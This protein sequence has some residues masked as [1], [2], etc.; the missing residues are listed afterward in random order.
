VVAARAWKLRTDVAEVEQYKRNVEDA[1]SWLDITE[2]TLAHIG[3]V[4]HRARELAVDGA[5]GTKALEDMQK[6]KAE[7]EQ[8][9]IQLIHLSNTTYAGRYI[10]SGYKTD[11]KFIDDNGNFVIDV[12]NS[13]NIKYEVGIGDDIVINVPGG[14]LFN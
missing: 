11:T 4:L 6:I 5:N 9:R 1:Q 2:T 7:M 14:E 12:A 8:L 10:F 13:E 3:D